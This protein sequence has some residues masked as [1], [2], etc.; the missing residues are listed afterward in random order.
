MKRG[1]KGRGR[2]W[3]DSVR[4]RERALEGT[5]C[6]HAPGHPGTGA[7]GKGRDAHAYL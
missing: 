1:E 4:G 7:K 2:V 5:R 6:T 3:E